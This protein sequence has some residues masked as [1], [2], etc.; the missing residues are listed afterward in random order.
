[1]LSEFIH[2]R[3]SYPAVQLAPEQAHQWSVHLGPLVLETN[4]LKNRTPAVD[5]RPTCLTLLHSH[6][7]EKRTISSPSWGV[8]RV[9]STGPAKQG[10]L[11]IVPGMRIPP[12]SAEFVIRHYYRRPPWLWLVFYFYLFKNE[13]FNSSIDSD[14]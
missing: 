10:S 9:V 11:G 8:Q 2:S 7:C 6:L 14:G 3:L 1:M 4:P 5:R 12:I 13:N